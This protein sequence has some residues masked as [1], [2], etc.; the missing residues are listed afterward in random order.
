[1]YKK[2]LGNPAINTLKFLFIGISPKEVGWGALLFVV[3]VLL[4][5]AKFIIGEKASVGES[6]GLE[7]IG[8]VVGGLGFLLVVRGVLKYICDLFNVWR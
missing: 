6:W 7:A 3:G 1:M 5:T 2:K 4:A 8:I